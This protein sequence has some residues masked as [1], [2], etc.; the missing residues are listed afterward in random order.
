ME[1]SAHDSAAESANDALY[2]LQGIVATYTPAGGTAKSV[3][4]LVE[5]RGRSTQTKQGVRITAHTLR[6]M[7]RTSEVEELGR[8][9]TFRLAEESIDFKVLPSSV[10]NDGLEWDF[11]AN[12]DVTKT[13]GN[14]DA[15]PDR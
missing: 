7:V 12:A 14:V 6:A 9:D 4:L 3:T 5:D 13:L 8:G 15:V 10:T 2:E 1:K 11:E